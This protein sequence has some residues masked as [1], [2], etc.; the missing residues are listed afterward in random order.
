MRKRRSDRW[1]RAVSS[2]AREAARNH[3]E[4]IALADCPGVACPSKP[5]SPREGPTCWQPERRE[6]LGQQQTLQ[7]QHCTN[8]RADACASVPSKPVG[9]GKLWLPAFLGW[10]QEGKSKAQIV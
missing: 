3:P 7:K 4:S 2:S 10:N 6:G 9:K 8:H 5:S 1:G